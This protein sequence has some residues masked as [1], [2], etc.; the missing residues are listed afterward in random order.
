MKTMWSRV[1]SRS[2]VT[3]DPAAL[4]EHLRSQSLPAAGQFRGDDFGWTRGELVVQA[5][6]T[7]VYIE[8]YLT[9]TDDLRDDLNTW[10][11]WLE[12]QDHEPRHR[13]LME[14]V[15]A[16]RQLVTIRRP[17]DAAD[18]VLLERLCTAVCQWLAVQTDGVY[19]VDDQGFFAAD[20]TELLHEY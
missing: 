7:P 3:P 14:H 16:A 4:L 10:A 6:A 5:G 20:G 19:Q 1:F 2:D 12:T 9:A 13:S 17:L 18:E 8:R 15:I 11:A